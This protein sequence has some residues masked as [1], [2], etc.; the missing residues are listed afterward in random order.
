[1]HS[2]RDPEH[3]LARQEVWSGGQRTRQARAARE[4]ASDAAAARPAE[5]AA[6]R[7]RGHGDGQVGKAAR[8][9]RE[10]HDVGLPRRRLLPAA[11]QARL[12]A[13]AAA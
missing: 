6:R 11:G 1:M 7:Q 8:L 12:A 4:G 5:A 2:Q 13:A 10:R 9:R 3:A